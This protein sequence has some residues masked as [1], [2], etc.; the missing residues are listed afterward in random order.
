MRRLDKA[1]CR[2]TAAVKRGDA[3]ARKATEFARLTGSD[4]VLTWMDDVGR[5]GMFSSSAPPNTP[6]NSADMFH[7]VAAAHRRA[8]KMADGMMRAAD[9]GVSWVGDANVSGT[10]AW[11]NQH[12]AEKFVDPKALRLGFAVPQ[13]LR[14]AA[15]HVDDE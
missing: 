1:K 11:S 3:L 9:A 2:R 7:A 10:Q 14:D 13:M 12:W 5:V 15:A 4:V 6:V 8:A